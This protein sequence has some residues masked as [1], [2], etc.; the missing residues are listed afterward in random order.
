MVVL[1]VSTSE[2]KFTRDLVSVEAVA[3]SVLGPDVDASASLASLFCFLLLF[4][5]LFLRRGARS[6]DL[7]GDFD[8]SPCSVSKS[9]TRG[10]KLT[11]S[12]SP[13]VS[14]SSPLVGWTV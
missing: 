10:A 6:G 4:F 8:F 3:E 7:A 14:A 9:L 13:S 2:A 12:I 11:R 1:M 5:L